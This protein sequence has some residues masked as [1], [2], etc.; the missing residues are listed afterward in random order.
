MR[1]SSSAFTRLLKAP[2]M[3]EVQLSEAHA[4]VEF[5]DVRVPGE[6]GRGHLPG[7]INIPLARIRQLVRGLNSNREYW[8]Y[9][10]TGRRSAS[11]TFLL[12]ERGFNAKLIKG[13]VAVTQLVEGS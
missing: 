6:F 4:Q 5:M 3:I 11:A 7:A 1:L 12:N 9:C 10:D 2:L 8:V 13:G